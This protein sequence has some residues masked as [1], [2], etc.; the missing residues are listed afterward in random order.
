M[1]RCETWH[2]ESCVTSP[3]LNAD[4]KVNG[5]HDAREVENRFAS[6]INALNA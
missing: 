5:V 6:E 1:H 3:R 2:D 4:V